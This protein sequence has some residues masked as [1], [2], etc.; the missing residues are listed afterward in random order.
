MRA[1]VLASLGI[2]L[3][4]GCAVLL[5]NT[6]WTPQQTTERDAEPTYAIEG[7]VVVE[8]G[9]LPANVWVR[10]SAEQGGGVRSV[11]VPVKPDGA[12]RADDLPPGVYRL[13]AA[14]RGDGADR[15]LGST[16]V[17]VTGADVRGVTLRAS[18]S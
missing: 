13:R 14:Q 4:M 8:S 1:R 10:L 16:N 5:F 18:G 6:Y 9:A 3:T 12:F 11:S 15:D 7:R 17:T 2:A